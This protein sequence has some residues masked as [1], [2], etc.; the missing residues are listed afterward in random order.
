MLPNITND[1]VKVTVL[2]HVYRVRTQPVFKVDVTNLLVFP[3][4]LI[5]IEAISDS[6]PLIFGG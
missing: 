6:I 3:E 2:E 4:G 5:S 1:I